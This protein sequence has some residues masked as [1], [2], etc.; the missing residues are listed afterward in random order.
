[1]QT[2]PHATTS[3]AGAPTLAAGVAPTRIDLEIVAEL[4]P[5]GVRVLDLGCGDGALLR[6]LVDR[7]HVVARGVEIS[8]EGVRQCIAKG[9]TVSHAD[10]DEGLGDYPDG[11]FDYVILSQTLQT[12]HKPDLVLKEMLR[13]GRVGIVSFPNFGYWRVGL[14]LLTT[15]RMPKND[16]LPY[17]WYDT[18]NIHLLTVADFHSFCAGHGICISRALYLN[19]G[20]RI[21]LWPNLRAKIAIFE[22]HRR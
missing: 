12:V 15:G 4:V 3:S 20:R 8:E 7:K 10:L 2:E 22:I 9:L 19:D 13:V 5:E 11:A 21:V 14:Q 17:E 1:M 16:Y 6:L 18:P